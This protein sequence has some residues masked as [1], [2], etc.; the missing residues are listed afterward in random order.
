MSPTRARSDFWRA[1]VI[2]TDADVSAGVRALVKACPAMAAAYARV[3]APPL[4]R[5]HPGLEGL[6]RIIV[7][8]QLSVASAAAIYGRVLAAIVPLDAYTLAATGDERLR[9]AGL[10]RGKIATLR[11]LAAAILDGRLD[12]DALA[13]AS[14]DVVQSQLLDVPG[15]GPWTVNIYLMFCRGDRDA[16]ASG[17]LALQIG[18]QWL[19]N[20]PQRPTAAELA[21]IAERWRSNRGVAARLVWSYYGQRKACG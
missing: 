6:V 20:L 21:A 17:D 1:P 15:I 19:M 16:F 11:A 4:R 10:S 5:W 2:A 13:T 3:G 9:A 18:V 8:Q 14:Q 12:L 7:G